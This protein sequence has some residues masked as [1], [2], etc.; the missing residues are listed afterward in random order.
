M[1]AFRQ[2]VPS[3]VTMSLRR[4]SR[5]VSTQ[6]DPAANGEPTRPAAPKRKAPAPSK[7]RARK[8]AT[9]KDDAKMDPPSRYEWRKR[10][11]SSSD[12][13]VTPERPAKKQK[14]AGEKIPPSAEGPKQVAIAAYSTGDIDDMTSPPPKGRSVEPHMTNALLR[15]PKGTRVTPKPQNAH[16]PAFGQSPRMKGRMT[17]ENLLDKACA[18]LIKIDANLK[19]VIDQNYCRV[20]SAEGLAEEVD[21][22]RSLVSGILAQQVSG[23]AAN[24]IKNKFIA[25][26]NEDNKE[27]PHDFPTPAQVAR[28]DISRLRTAGLSQRKAEYVQGLAEKFESGE[29]SAQL[30]A[31]ASD[32]EVLEKLI[33]VRGLGKWSVEMFMMFALKRTDVLST[34]DLG[35]QYAAKLALETPMKLIRYTGAVWLHTLAEMWG[36]LR[37]RAGS[38]S[39]WQ[40]K[41]CWIV[42]LH[43]HH[44]GMS[45]HSI[46]GVESDWRT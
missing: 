34:G 44:T 29:L 10:I 43:F 23:A 5:R 11:E 36:S 33:A 8:E 12:T 16:D 21:P 45:D 17:T 13:N 27:P 20:F 18:H 9:G 40:S 32:E 7:A 14:T 39:T 37:I 19:T 38:G 15:T 30:L 24:S 28:T 3:F 22:F 46:V 35:I 42:P 1:L 2:L 26:F 6:L 4:S 25:L 41:R 31:D